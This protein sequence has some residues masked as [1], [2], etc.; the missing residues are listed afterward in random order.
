MHCV[1]AYLAKGW[2]LQLDQW[3]HEMFAG[4]PPA[5]WYHRAYSSTAGNFV[6]NSNKTAFLG[7]TQIFVGDSAG[8]WSELAGS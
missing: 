6:D 3:A 7:H 2:V 1:S 4:I 8:N 5:Y